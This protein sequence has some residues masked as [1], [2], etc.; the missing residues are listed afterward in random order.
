MLE[1]VQTALDEC[2][3]AVRI[4]DRLTDSPACIVNDEGA[5][6]ARQEKVL[7]EAGHDVP[8]QKRILEL[9]A[10]HPVVKKLQGLSEDDKFADWSA[11]LYD[12]ALLA[13][14]TLP[15]DPA[16]FSKRLTSLMAGN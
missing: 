7:R 2:V 13:E 10:G 4:T 8:K 1:R 14:G 9:N 6:S 3:K 15:G 16:A 11:L 5:M 12:Q